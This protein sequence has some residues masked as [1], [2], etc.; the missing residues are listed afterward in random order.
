VFEAAA[1][2]QADAE[3]L[4]PDDVREIL[5]PKVLAEEAERAH[6]N[7]RAVREYEE[8]RA[9]SLDGKLHPSSDQNTRDCVS[10]TPEP[11]QVGKRYR[12]RACGIA[13]IISVG[14][15]IVAQYEDG[16]E[17]ECKLDGT[18]A[19]DGLLG[20]HR[21]P[22]D[23]LPGAV[24]DELAES[25]LDDK[26]HQRFMAGY[27][28]GL[29]DGIAL[30][31]RSPP[32]P[33]PPAESAGEMTDEYFA[34]LLHD[35]WASARSEDEGWLAA[36]LC[37]RELLQ[38]EGAALAANQCHDGYGDEYGNHR[39]REVDAWKARAERAEA[40]IERARACIEINLQARPSDDF[41]KGFDVGLR[42]AAD[43][44]GLTITPARDLTVTWEGVK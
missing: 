36:A 19:I 18:H 34:G 1:S 42:L 17:L 43:K 16:A 8:M 10:P 3:L 33:E 13:R 6:A 37:A 4:S 31:R 20:S 7:T 24:D 5:N 21:F 38:P 14:E 30:E 9:K 12:T 11:F 27:D 40:A 44:L 26:G 25:P 2:K 22:R 35:A 32:T 28:A 15:R 39:C 29:K 41:E 23:L